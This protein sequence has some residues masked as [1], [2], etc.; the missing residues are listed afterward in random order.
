MPS[1]TLQQ[2]PLYYRALLHLARH[3]HE[4]SDVV[5]PLEI[6]NDGIADAIGRTR[7]QSSATIAYLVEQGWA[8][9]ERHRVVDGR[10]L[11][12]LTLTPGGR[13]EAARATRIANSLGCRPEDVIKAPPSLF[14]DTDKLL[15]RCLD[16]EN[17]VKDLRRQIE[18]FIGGTA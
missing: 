6:T 13:M 17:Q 18:S 3:D 15:T 16:L 4:R 2:F 10:T 12:T 11:K 14:G 5:H 9:H 8:V 7:P 1:L